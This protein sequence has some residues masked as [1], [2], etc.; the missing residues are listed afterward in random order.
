MERSKL[1]KQNRDAKER[2]GTRYNHFKEEFG[3]LFEEMYD[4]KRQQQEDIINTEEVDKE[5]R[6]EE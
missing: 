6:T 4:K 3:D 5:N 2:F 1:K